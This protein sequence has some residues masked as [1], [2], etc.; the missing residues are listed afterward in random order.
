[1]KFCETCQ[2]EW[3]NGIDR[4]PQCNSKLVHH[5]Y[6]S[7]YQFNDAKRSDKGILFGII[8]LALLILVGVIFAIYSTGK[9]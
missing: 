6:K 1:M 4:C 9:L 2:E 5:I 8:I 7:E 3:D